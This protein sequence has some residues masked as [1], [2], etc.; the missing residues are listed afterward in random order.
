MKIILLAGKPNAGKTCTLNL[1]YDQITD[2]G[3]KNIVVP[4]KKAG[5]E[6][7]DFQCVVTCK[8]KKVAIYT[9]GD[10][11]GE[12]VKVLIKYANCDVLVLAYSM[13]F[14]VELD[15]LV[16][17]RDYHHVV[18]KTVSKAD[19]LKANQTDRDRI[20]AEI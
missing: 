2:K 12:F 18:R 4:K 20:I 3:K 9:A 17:N 11:Y 8:N 13:K 7:K 6:K 14:A 1:L 5:E 16:E 19:Q 15:K 10:T